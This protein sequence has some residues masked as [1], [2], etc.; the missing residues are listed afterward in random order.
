[1]RK[2]MIVF[3]ALLVSACSFSQHE[4]RLSE[5]EQDFFNLS[6]QDRVNKFT[7][8]SVES[9]Y[10]LLIFGNQVVHPPA[11]YLASEFAKN[12]EVGLSFLKEKLV[13]VDDEVTIRDIAYTIKEMDRLGFYDVKADVDLMSLLEEKVT[14]MNGQWKPVVQNMLKEM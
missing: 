14:S 10:R 3:L 1:M 4:A 8:Y 7:E 12:G 11:M 2:K 5:V 9:Q 6:I 13:E